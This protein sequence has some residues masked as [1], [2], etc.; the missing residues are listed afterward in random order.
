[1]ILSRGVSG[2]RNQTLVFNLPGNPENAQ[3][4]LE[5]VL[6]AIPHC[7]KTMRQQRPMKKSATQSASGAARAGET[8]SRASSKP[9]LRH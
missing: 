4:A 2:I 5:S 1:M 6:P 8:K 3:M 9:K 7:I